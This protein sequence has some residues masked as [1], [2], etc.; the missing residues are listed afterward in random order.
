MY[1]P[2]ECCRRSQVYQEVDQVI[3]ENIL[4]MQQLICHKGQVDKLAG[5]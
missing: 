1:Q 4:A 5:S 3:A 2:K